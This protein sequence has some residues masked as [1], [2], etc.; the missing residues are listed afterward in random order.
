MYYRRTS[1]AL[2]AAFAALCCLAAILPPPGEPRLHYAVTVP[3]G[4]AYDAQASYYRRHRQGWNQRVFVFASPVRSTL[5]SVFDT[6]L[7]APFDCRTLEEVWGYTNGKQD[8]RRALN[9]L[10]A[11]YGAERVREA[12]SHATK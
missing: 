12:L 4:G 5:P 10:I 3:D 7:D 2:I 6:D 8:C 1:I 11:R 9:D